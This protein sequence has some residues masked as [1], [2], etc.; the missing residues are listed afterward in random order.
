MARTP[1]RHTDDYDS[2]WKEVLE[3]FFPAFMAFFFPEAHAE[4]DWSQRYEFLDKELAKIVRDANLGK[5]LA[6][7]LVKVRRVTGEEVWVL[8]HIEVQG[9]V[10]PEFPRRMYVYNYRVFDRY[11][12][13]VASM[14]VLAD[15]DPKWRPDRFEYELWGSHT[16]LRFPLVKL[17]ALADRWDGLEMSPNPFAPVVMAHLK[18]QETKGAPENRMVWKLRIVR[19]L[20]ERGFG[21]QEVLELFRVIDWMMGLPP[22]LDQA[23]HHSLQQYEGERNMPYITSIERI[24]L[25]KG[26][27]EGFRQGIERGIEQG[28]EQGIEKGLRQAVVGA[29]LVRFERV[30]DVLRD[31]LD[32]IDEVDELNRLHSVAIRAESLE[33]FERELR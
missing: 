24:G 21:R 1:S 14:A 12:R 3:H 27:E 16:G 33:A 7:K 9:W 6:D 13:P 15:D 22:G 26:R 17:C 23:F 18:T 10:D 25:E 20:Y 11:G 29:L 4:I 32:R 5:R 19:G 28:I 30:P 31:A 2:P 8:I